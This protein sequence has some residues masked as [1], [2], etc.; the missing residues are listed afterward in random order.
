LEIILVDDGSSDDTA[1]IIDEYTDKYQNIRSLHQQN[2]GCSAARNQAFDVS[3]GQ[4]IT[5]I[6]ADDKA[7]PTMIDEL[8][9]AIVDEDASV[10]V[11]RGTLYENNL[12]CSTAKETK[13]KIFTGTQAI[14]D[15]M[16]GL[17]GYDRK[18]V[19]SGS[20]VLKMYVWGKLYKREVLFREG[21]AI[22]FKYSL[23]ED[24]LYNTQV[25]SNTM[26]IVAIDRKLYY[27]NTDAERSSKYLKKEYVLDRLSV[28]DEY[29]KLVG[30]YPYKEKAM[31]AH[32]IMSQY[33]MTLLKLT[34]LQKDAYIK[35]CI[36]N[37]RKQIKLIR[38]RYAAFVGI[39]LQVVS[40]MVT[41]APRI[42]V[43]ISTRYR[44]RILNA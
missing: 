18:S 37:V 11:C 7:A 2:M 28:L 29:V 6:D 10:S 40:Y 35:C 15:L 13:A 14:L 33:I 17:S 9:R 39:K 30:K 27:Y 5:Y 42:L 32:N 3:S 21:S 36:R 22:R 19:L 31:I 38:K 1:E 24:M 34:S 26:S 8:Y 41:I 20:S 4:M 23:N 12:D 44:N 16:G 43:R 25:Y